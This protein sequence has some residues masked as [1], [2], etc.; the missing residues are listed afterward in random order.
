[1][2]IINTFLCVVF[3]FFIVYFLVFN[4]KKLHNKE[5]ENKYG[6]FYEGMKAD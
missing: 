5:F 3:P 6:A 1:M 4:K 2:A